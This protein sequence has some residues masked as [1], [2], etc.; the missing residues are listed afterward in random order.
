MKKDYKTGQ[1]KD[2]FRT[3]ASGPSSPAGR[4]LSMSS[5]EGSNS[6]LAEERKM[7]FKL[8]SLDI[9]TR[10]QSKNFLQQ[11]TFSR[12]IKYLNTLKQEKNFNKLK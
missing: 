7:E 9:M 1:L 3:V 2:A 5:I 12:E 10:N 4:K 6:I 11:E 8:P